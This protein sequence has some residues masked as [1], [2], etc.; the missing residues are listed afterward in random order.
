MMIRWSSLSCRDPV[1]VRL[2]NLQFL[3]KVTE[4]AVFDQLHCHLSDRSKHVIF[5]DAYSDITE[6]SHG[7]PQGSCLGPL[8]LTI[9]ASKLFE[10][11]KACLPIAH[12]Y[13]DDS[14]LSLSFQPDCELSETEAITS[15]ERCIKAVRAWMLRWSYTL[16]FKFFSKKPFFFGT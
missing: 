7:V 1:L 12:A 9:Y 11:V 3:S 2:S 16:T 14:L 10:V 4:K 15:L 13:A 8:L 6:L 5:G